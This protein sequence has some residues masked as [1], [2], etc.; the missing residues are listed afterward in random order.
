MVNKYLKKYIYPEERHKVIDDLKLI[1]CN[2]GI[3]KS[4]KFIR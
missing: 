1:Y 4:I 2:N 3:S